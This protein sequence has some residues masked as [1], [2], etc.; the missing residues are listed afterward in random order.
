MK[1]R[2]PILAVGKAEQRTRACKCPPG[3]KEEK[4]KQLEWRLRGDWSKTDK[5]GII[6]E[7]D[8]SAGDKGLQVLPWRKPQEVLAREALKSVDVQQHSSGRVRLQGP[9]GRTMLLRFIILF[10]RTILRQRRQ[11]ARERDIRSKTR[12]RNIGVL[13]HLGRMSRGV[14]MLLK[15]GISE[16]SSKAD[17]AVRRDRCPRGRA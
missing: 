13:I 3:G 10:L 11:S 7:D 4:G 16:M 14:Q 6:I 5:V 1:R 17:W 8:V 2:L 9:R 15:Q 12:R